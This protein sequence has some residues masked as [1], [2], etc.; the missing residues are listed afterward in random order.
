MWDKA[1]PRYQSAGGNY[2]GGGV[3]QGMLA[4]MG[5]HQHSRASCFLQQ[6]LRHVRVAGF[7]R[8]VHVDDMIVDRSLLGFICQCGSLQSARQP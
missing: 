3:W 4:V 7:L 2:G 6:G 1:L 5:V 8:Q